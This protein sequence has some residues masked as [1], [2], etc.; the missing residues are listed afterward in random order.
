[1]LSIYRETSGPLK[2]NTAPELPDEVIWMDLLNPTADEIAFVEQRAGVRVPTAEALSEVETSSRLKVERG[3]LY[4]STP[5]VAD[6]QT[7]NPVLS[8]AGFILSPRL[9]VTVRFTPL[10]TFDA[11]TERI[12][13]D[14]ELCSSI[15]VF[16]A[17]M[18]AIVDRGADVLEHLG[19]ELDRLSRSVFRGD[20]NQ[21]RHPARSNEAQRLTLSQVGDIGDRLSLARDTLLGIGRITH[22]ASDIG[23]AWIAPEFQSRLG[24]VAKDVVSL[25]DFETQLANKVQFLLDAVLGFITI[26][27]NEL[28]KVLT[29]VSVV[30]IPP[31]LVAGIYGMNFKNMPELNW[32]WGY[33]FGLAAIALSAILPL[34]WFKVRGWF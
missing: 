25:N 26:A 4:L 23:H 5:V 6:S 19:A 33:P 20:P 28:F 2:Q 27:Q 8:P 22:F 3:V 32:A 29:I 14:E 15:G 12:R 16:T 9:L 34:I 10:S 24:A 30:G 1:M 11:V 18:E 31:T 21:M 7:A 17:L 13:V